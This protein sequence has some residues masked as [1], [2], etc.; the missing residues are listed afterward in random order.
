[1]T[2]TN[3]TLSLPH[4][5]NFQDLYTRDGLLRVDA[6]FL[7]SLPP[8]LQT[9]L[10]SARAHPSALNQD[11]ESTLILSLSPHV[12]DFIAHLFSIEPELRLLQSQHNILAPQQTVKRKFVLPK[13]NRVTPAQAAAINA[14]AVA[15]ELEVFFQSPLTE[16]SYADHVARWMTDDKTHAR[17]LQLAADYA[18][19]AV[20]TPEGQSKHHAGVLFKLPHKLDPY[21]LV[22]L[23]SLT[24]HGTSQFTFHENR[25]RR[26]EGFHLT[27]AGTD[28][29]GAMDQAGYCVKCHHQHKDSCSKGLREKD[30][31]PKAT[32]FGVPLA[33]CPLEEKISEMNEAKQAGQPIGALAI[34]II[35]NPMCAGTGH[36]ICNDC[37]KSCIYQKQEPV[38][39]PQVETRSLKDILELPYGFEIYSLLTRWNP[40]NFSRPL[41]KP[42]TGKNVLVV[43]LGPA[44]FTLAHH[45][46]NDGHTVAAVDGLKIEPLPPHLS[47]VDPLGHRHPFTPIRNISDVYE[48][49]DNRVMAG[50]GGVAEYGITVRWNKNFL[51]VI[52]LLLE[53]R[54]QFAMFGGVRFGG[55]LT[56]DSAFDIGFDHIALSAGAGRPTVIPMKNGLARGVRQA[57][58]FLMALQL[59]GAAKTDS[60]ANLQV[61]LPVVVI[62]GGLTAIDTA[63]ESLAYYPVQ[64]EKFLQRYETLVADLGQDR[65]EQLWNPEERS[66]AQEFLSHARA[67]RAERALAAKEMRAPHI[68]ELLQSWGG[69]TVAYR[70]RLVDSPSYTL[71]HEEVHKALEEGIRFAEC[72][73]PDEVELDQ[74]GAAAA[75]KLDHFHYDPTANELTKTG[76]IITLPARSIL[77]AAGTQ[78]NTVLAREDPLNVRLDG[79]YFQA[80]DE[81]GQPVKPERTSK[82]KDVHVLMSLRPDGRAI[83]FFGD[84]HPSFAGNVV[85]A[86]GSAKQGYPIVSRIL[87]RQVSGFSFQG[88]EKKGDG[89]HLSPPSSSSLN[90]EP[91]KTEPSLLAKLNDELRA[92]VHDV[93]RLTPNIVE[94]IVRAPLAARAFQPGQFFRLQNYESSAPRAG[95]TTLAMEGLALTGAAVDTEKGLLTTIV[96]EMGGSS[97]LCALLKPGQPIILMGPTGEPTETPPCETVILVGG[98]LGNAVL[99]SIGQRLRAQGS[100]VIYFAGYKKIID[101][102]KVAEIEKAADV[103]TWC[104]DE[105]PGFTPS[106]PQDSAFVGNIVQAML[107]YATGQLSQPLPTSSF[108]TSPSL[109]PISLSEATRLIAIGSD[110]MM[111]GVQEAR[112]TLLKPYLHPNHHAIASINSPMQCMMKEI[113]AQCLQTHRD[114]ATGKETVVFSCANQDQPLDHVRFDTLRSRLSQNGVQEKLTKLWIDRSLRLLNL[115]PQV[116]PQLKPQAAMS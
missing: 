12:D 7:S 100:R 54:S 89:S 31:K 114:P 91:L 62:G 52:R 103:I 69:V 61:R 98:G 39:I 5:L 80:I 67:I 74:Y 56:V 77:V 65:V 115:R 90:P 95:D 8:E 42:D 53:R 68:T 55:T 22:P 14:T 36:R 43:G 86:M 82:P 27:D 40:L 24:I 92:T 10:L 51:K 111:R 72:L 46:M 116:P 73:S 32:V 16:Q 81:S 63:T 109:P 79:R 112:H 50:F 78:P 28:L 29:T 41:P 110:G 75:L 66:T 20:H 84:L 15:A 104:C 85:K 71:N 64:V 18:A 49:L 93:I 102:Y 70:R 106:R 108:P 13:T 37:M 3:A 99:F 34:V 2:T 60:L 97:D 6:A 87:A 38:D 94:I 26:R 25:L 76:Q 48:R 105:P 96:L 30:G 107:A 59:T 44:G 101:R 45:L 113:C 33:G 35:D 47:G 1:M 57:S 58:D 4:G 19:Y 83:S 88:S 17:H 9:Q 11:A 21:H 23:E